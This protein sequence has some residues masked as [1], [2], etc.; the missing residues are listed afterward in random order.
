M[1]CAEQIRYN[2][3]I[4]TYITQTGWRIAQAAAQ[5]RNHGLWPIAISLT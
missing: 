5:N 4:I 1:S 3:E 2:I